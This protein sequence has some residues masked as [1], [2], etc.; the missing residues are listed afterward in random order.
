MARRPRNLDADERALWNRVA[1]QT[2]PLHPNRPELP[3]DR[4]ETPRK[5]PKSRATEIPAFDL[6]QNAPKTSARHD[7]A[8][9]LPEKFAATPV[10]MD[11][12]QHTR[13][14]RGKL[15]PEGRIDLHGMTMDRAHPA[16][17]RFILDA[18]S[19]GKRL[20]LVITGKG[21]RSQDDGP[22]PVRHG[23]LK[24]QVPQWLNMAPLAGVVLQ[25]TPA[26]RKHGG[27]GAYYVYLRRV[28]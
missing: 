4:D 28:R 21:R 2:V 7:L 9:S 19:A 26:H 25:V 13:M 23:I 14:T 20:V 15:S 22:I 8:P 3:E 16:L 24:H 5:P 17:T 10:Q 27:E 18:H 1:E 11:R 6:G 12:K